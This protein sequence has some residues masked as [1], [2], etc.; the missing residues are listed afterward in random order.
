MTF[1]IMVTDDN[2]GI[3]S[4][5]ADNAVMVLELVSQQPLTEVSPVYML[6]KLLYM[7]LPDS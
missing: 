6:F 1:D 2:P 4:I 5:A 3:A 7:L